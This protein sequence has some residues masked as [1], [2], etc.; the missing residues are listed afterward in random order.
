MK[1]SN[2]G[3]LTFGSEAKTKGL[4]AKIFSKIKGDNSEEIECGFRGTFNYEQSLEIST[5][6][7]VELFEKYQEYREDTHKE[8][9]ATLDKL[10]NCF[11][12]FE[13]ELR[14]RAATAV[15][16]WQE[17]LHRAKVKD[18]KQ[19]EEYINLSKE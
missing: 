8:N 14:E 18:Y 17:I 9:F 1:F 2:N 16:E 5:G 7:I 15:P 12:N 3:S 4:F 10:K 13:E 11:F 19:T 6:E